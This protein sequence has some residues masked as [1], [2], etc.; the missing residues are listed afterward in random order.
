MNRQRAAHDTTHDRHDVPS[1]EETVRMNLADKD[2][3]ETAV[4]RIAR[5]IGSVGISPDE[6]MIRTFIRQEAEKCL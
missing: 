3:M 1:L 6:G 2:L 5:Q 4:Y